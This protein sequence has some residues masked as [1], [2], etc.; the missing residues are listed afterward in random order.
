[1]A[2]FTI[3]QATPDNAPE[4][5]R[6]LDLFDHM[7][8]TPEQVVARML[9]CQNVLTTF[10]GELDGQPSALRACGSFHTCKATSRMPS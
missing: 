3:R 4:L 10:I 9:A 5:A 7:G 1:M 8:T 2:T 6:L